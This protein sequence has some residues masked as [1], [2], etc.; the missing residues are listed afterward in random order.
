[1]FLFQDVEPLKPG[2]AVSLHGVYFV[3]G[4]TRIAPLDGSAAMASDGTVRLGFFVHSTAESTNDFTVA[5]ITDA[6]F[7]GTVSFDSDGDFTPNGTLTM[8]VVDCATLTVP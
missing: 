1:M 6:T 3:T 4:L 5:G 8:Q 7:A 2:R